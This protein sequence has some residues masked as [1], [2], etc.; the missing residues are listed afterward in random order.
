MLEVK[1]NE[2]MEGTQKIRIR[3]IEKEGEV[4]KKVLIEI[5]Y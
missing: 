3:K 5:L 2:I 1:T 4:K